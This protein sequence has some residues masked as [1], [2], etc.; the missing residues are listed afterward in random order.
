[1]R[2]FELGLGILGGC[3]LATAYHLGEPFHS[4]LVIIG[5]FMIGWA[6]Q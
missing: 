1:M 5:G 6:T 2:L 4:A 3:L